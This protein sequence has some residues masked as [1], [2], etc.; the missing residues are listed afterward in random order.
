MKLIIGVN[1]YAGAGKDTVCNMIR[2]Q[3]IHNDIPTE[4]LAFANPLKRAT[5][6]AFGIPLE[7][8]HDEDKKDVRNSFWGL[9][10][11]EMLQ[12]V[13]TDC[14]RDIVRYDFWIKRMEQAVHNSDAE[15]ILISDVRF[16]NEAEFVWRMNGVI[17]IVSREGKTANV[18]IAN[19][20]SNNIVECE[21]KEK[22]SFAI[23]NSGTLSE[24]HRKVS[25]VLAQIA[26]AKF[27]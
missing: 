9:S 27:R 26:S 4:K 14:F 18:G 1:G 19:H 25:I 23:N 21:G 15:V 8:F 17:L 24:L 7:D 10:P 13:G 22:D 20:K 11:R 2:E 6:E 5:A 16:Q 12:K 3:L